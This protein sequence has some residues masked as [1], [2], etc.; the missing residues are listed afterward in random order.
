[1]QTGRSHWLTALALG[2]TAVFD[3]TGALI[4]RVL[5]S[6]LPPPPP[7]G[8]GGGPFEQA[9]R[10]LRAAQREAIDQVHPDRT[11]RRPGRGIRPGGAGA[12]HVA[13]DGDRHDD[14]AT[15]PA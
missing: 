4:Y 13:D 7:R 2:S 9:T 6:S 8:A 15:L 14:G 3:I 10:E 5:R 12:S 11:A 1:M